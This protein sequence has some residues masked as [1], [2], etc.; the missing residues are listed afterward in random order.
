MLQDG[1]KLKNK[2]ISH[3]LLR[4]EVI[5]SK[6]Y[7]LLFSFATMSFALMFIS[8]EAMMNKWHRM[9]SLRLSENQLYMKQV[10]FF[11]ICFQP[12]KKSWRNRIIR[13]FIG[14]QVESWNKKETSLQLF[15]LQVWITDYV[16][17]LSHDSTRTL[18][19]TLVILFLHIKGI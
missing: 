1:Q 2:S 9:E 8:H 16:L 3:T 15:S 5:S 7:S 10:Y 6:T 17:L 11:I 18:M 4:Y 13:V 19:T 14:V 12:C